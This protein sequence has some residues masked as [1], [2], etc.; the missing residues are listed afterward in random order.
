MSLS[1]GGYVVKYVGPDYPGAWGN[2]QM[3][4]HRWVMEQTLGR[5]L[6]PGE[7]VHHINGDKSD[8]RPDNLELWGSHQPKGTRHDDPPHCQTCTCAHGH[9]SKR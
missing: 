6:L 8:N 1:R 2:G 3:F 9:R 4:E 7:N 5:S